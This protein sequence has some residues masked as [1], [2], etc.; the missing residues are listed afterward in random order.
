MEI[1]DIMKKFLGFSV[2]PLFSALLSFITIPITTYLISP[3][4][5]G[6]ASFFTITITLMLSIIYLGIDQ[7][8]AREYFNTKNK[9]S[10]Y[11]NAIV[12]PLTIA[13]LLSIF[14]FLF[15]DTFL[16]YLFGEKNHKFVPLMFCSILFLVIIER[17]TLMSYRMEEKAL[18]FS[19]FSISSK[20]F[21]LIFTLIFLLFIE[22]SFIS[23]VYATFVGQV[24]STILLILFSKK[25]IC[26]NVKYF[27]LNTIKSL[28]K[29]GFPMLVSALVATFLNSG[30]QFFLRFFGNFNDVGMYAAALKIA[31]LI[32][33]VQASF[34]SFWI[35]LAY[36]W[37]NENLDHRYFKKVADSLTF[38]LAIFFIL[39]VISKKY[40]ILVL[41]PEYAEASQIVGLLSLTPI[42][43]T[44]SEAT[45]LGIVFSGKSYYSFISSVIALITNVALNLFFVP[46]YGVYAAAFAQATAF[47]VFYFLKLYFSKKEH[48]Y[49]IDYRNIISIIILFFTSLINLLSSNKV[50]IVNLITLLI[51]LFLYVPHIKSIIKK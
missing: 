2:G 44:L 38:L 37:N 28:L 8:F 11:F 42:I 27:D 48:F 15:R 4:E 49:I 50:I 36:R 18:Q 17:F 21:T 40:L 31:S 29:F 22:K 25:N 51:I 35:P 20:F 33:I 45:T 13:F 19:L 39:L 26:I 23:I 6:K 12:L 3:E 34:T 14:I 1:K 43:Y 47:V 24:F 5:F 10:L 30:G 7:S 16:L 32:N 46:R 41:S 9:K